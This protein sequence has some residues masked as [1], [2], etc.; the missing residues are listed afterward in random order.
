MKYQ[1]IFLIWQRRTFIYLFF[2]LC[3]WL[4][5]PGYSCPCLGPTEAIRRC[6]AP[7]NWQLWATMWM[8]RIKPRSLGTA[9]P[10]IF[11]NL[12]SRVVSPARQRRNFYKITCN[13][14]Q[15]FWSSLQKQWMHWYLFNFH[16]HLNFACMYVCTPYACSTHKGKKG[17]LEPWNCTFWVLGTKLEFSEGGLNHKDIFSVIICIFHLG[18]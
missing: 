12:N 5:L 7:W 14:I 17:V 18:N 4:F 2:I 6:Q 9:Q 16:L 15:V 8:L 11:S 3:A 10:A 1:D 13:L